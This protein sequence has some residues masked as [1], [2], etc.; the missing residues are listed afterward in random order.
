MA[1]WTNDWDDVAKGKEAGLSVISQ[2]ADMVYANLDN[3]II[4]TYQ[5]VREK[6]KYAF[7]VFYD[8]YQDWPD[9]ILQSAVMSWKYAVFTLLKIA[10]ESSLEPIVYRIGH[11]V[12]TAAGLGTFHPAIPEELKAEVLQ[13]VQ[14]I[15]DG[16]ID[17]I[18]E[19]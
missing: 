17:A 14:D 4:G 10:K 1:A 3:S 19:R 18:A 5:A 2:G 6:G 16:K 15:I 7:G 11:E 13:V 9:I 12:P 8:A